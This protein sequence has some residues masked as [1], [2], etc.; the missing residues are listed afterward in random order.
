MGN[1][2]PVADLMVGHPLTGEQFWVDVKG[3]WDPNAWWGTP[4]AVRPNLFYIL[5]LVGVDRNADRFFVLNQ[6]E[7]NTLIEQYRQAHPAAKPVGGF[8]WG[9]PHAFENR[10]EKLPSWNVGRI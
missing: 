5:V 7:F 6:S 10:W 8:N 9:D 2:T 3:M 1:N 4:K